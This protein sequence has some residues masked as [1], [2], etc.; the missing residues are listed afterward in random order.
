LPP[1]APGGSSIVDRFASDAAPLARLNAAV[2][3]DEGL[4]GAGPHGFSCPIG[5]GR[6]LSKAFLEGGVIAN[7]VHGIGAPQPKQK[8]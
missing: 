1:L 5:R 7:R 6:K 2:Q 3:F 8:N 4:I